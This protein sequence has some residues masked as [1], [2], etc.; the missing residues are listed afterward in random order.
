[1]ATK[2]QPDDRLVYPISHF[3]NGP[4][5]GVTIV[6]LGK[7]ML[8]S[9]LASRGYYI[10][11]LSCVRFYSCTMYCF[12]T[13]TPDQG[14]RGCPKDV[15]CQVGA[16]LVKPCTPSWIHTLGPT[17]IRPPSTSCVGSI[18]LLVFRIGHIRADGRW[19]HIPSYGPSLVTG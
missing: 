18:V 11:S 5:I 10:R 3:Q 13:F 16:V 12:R 17:R 7:G 9:C 19:G 14:G 4:L 2:Y 6:G 15:F 8:D 1:M